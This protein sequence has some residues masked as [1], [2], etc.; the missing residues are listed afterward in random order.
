[1]KTINE[2]FQKNQKLT[3]YVMG[4]PVIA[5]YQYHWLNKAPADENAIPYISH[6]DFYSEKNIISSTGYRSY[7][8][9]IEQ[10]LSHGNY[11]DVQELVTSIGRAIAKENG[12]EVGS[13]KTQLTLF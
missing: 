13:A 2:C 5:D 1:M 4:Y 9:Q 6:I 8:F 7:F 12:F 11:N 10:A 3:I